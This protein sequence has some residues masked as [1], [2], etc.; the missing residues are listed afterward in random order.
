VPVLKLIWHSICI[1]LY[2]G[3]EFDIKMEKP[4]LNKRVLKFLIIAK[5]IFVPNLNIGCYV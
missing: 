1:R 3:F 4:K 2:A 5:L